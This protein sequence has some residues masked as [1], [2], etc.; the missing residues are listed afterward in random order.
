MMVNSAGK[1][2]ILQV[3]YLL[4]DVVSG[5]RGAVTHCKESDSLHQVY[6]LAVGYQKVHKRLGTVLNMDNARRKK[7][8]LPD[9]FN[10]G[11]QQ[12][13]IVTAQPIA[14]NATLGHVDASP[15]DKEARLHLLAILENTSPPYESRH[16]KTPSNSLH[17]HNLTR[18]SLQVSLLSTQKDPKA[19]P[20]LEIYGN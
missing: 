8:R 20:R 4:Y 3:L 13:R 2:V 19:A 18:A 17:T 16:T 9:G 1:E 5:M 15:R 10:I 12:L 11:R 7:P 6:P 14:R